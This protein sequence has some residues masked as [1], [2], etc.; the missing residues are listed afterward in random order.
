[1][2][3]DSH[4]II[5]VTLAIVLHVLVMASFVVAFDWERQHL[6][7]LPLAVTATLVVES[8]VAPPVVRREPEPEVEEPEPEPEPEEPE[9]DP[10]AEARVKAEEQARLDELRRE[11]QRKQAEDRARLQRIE[12]E[13]E[14]QQK[15]EEEA[16]QKAADE[17]RRKAEEE[18]RLERQRVEAEQRRKEEEERQRR[19]NERLRREAE[20]AQLQAQIDAEAERLAAR[21]SED[22]AAY[23]FA[24]KQKVERA[25]VAPAS[26]PRNLECEV[27]V[28]QNQ[29][30]DVVSASVVRCNGD[31]IVVRS[32]ETAV[33]KASPLP[34][35]PNPLLFDTNLRF[36]FKPEQ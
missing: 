17:V 4:N 24:I 14:A 2:L 31:A 10:S 33:K 11:Q 8:E 13:K 6:E 18:A 35:P 21:S 7:P 5:P 22:M 30:G 15:A 12:D 25:W 26:A 3:R 19:E 28:R 34:R 1:L 16:R 32:I 23:M 9:P 27:A 29:N 36:I 20:T